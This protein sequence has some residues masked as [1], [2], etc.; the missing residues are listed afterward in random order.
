MA[1]IAKWLN[2]A[3]QNKQADL[4]I[5]DTLTNLKKRSKL[6]DQYVPFKTY[7]TRKFLGYVMETI[8]TVAS[9]ISYGAEPPATQHGTFRRITAEMMKSGLSYVYDENKMW[10]MK[11]EPWK[12]QSREQGNTIQA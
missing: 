9:V 3:H 7:S 8:N 12:L 2:E 4:V 6:L 11:E 5:E 1:Y 10:D